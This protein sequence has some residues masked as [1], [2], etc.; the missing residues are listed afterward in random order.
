MGAMKRVGGAC[1]HTKEE[2]KEKEENTQQMSSVPDNLQLS[3]VILT[4]ECHPIVISPLRPP[5]PSHFFIR[6]TAV[7]QPRIKSAHDFVGNSTDGRREWGS[8]AKCTV[9]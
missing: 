3:L 8:G 7:C 1:A 6:C 4:N 2:D 5:P 9:L